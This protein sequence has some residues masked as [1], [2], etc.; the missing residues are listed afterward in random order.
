MRCSTTDP[1]LIQL[2]C[3]ALTVDVASV[4]VA[5]QLECSRYRGPVDLGTHKRS[6]LKSGLKREHGPGI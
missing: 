1:S 5:P 6:T 2:L 4:A 3:P